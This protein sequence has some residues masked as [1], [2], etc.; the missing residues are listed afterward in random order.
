MAAE[1]KEI[2]FEEAI[3]RLE[4]VVLELEDGRLP[5][6]KALELFAEGTELARIC[7]RHLEDAEQRVLI[8]TS[9]EKGGVGLKEIDSMPT[10]GGGRNGEF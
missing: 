2:S 7:N 8:L 5:L 9:D 10:A 4:A 6:E 3:T 1:D